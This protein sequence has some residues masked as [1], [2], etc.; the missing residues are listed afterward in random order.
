[1]RRTACGY[2]LPTRADL[3]V[4]FARN[5]ASLPQ[6]GVQALAIGQPENAPL[7]AATAANLD[8][9]ALKEDGLREAPLLTFARSR[10]LAAAVDL[11]F[12]GAANAPLPAIL[13]D[14]A[15]L[16]AVLP[17]AAR[18]AD[19]AQRYAAA[20]SHPAWLAGLADDEAFLDQ[21][22]AQVAAFAALPPG[23][24]GLAVAGGTVQALGLGDSLKSW[25]GNAAV[26]VR[27]AVS[28]L[29]S[30]A[31][32]A[33]VGTAKEGVREGFLTFPGLV[34]P[35]AS[36]LIGRFFGDVFTYMENRQ[37]ILDRVLADI[38]LA[39]QAKRPG[40]SEL[41][42]VAHSF[43]GIILYDI[44]TRFRPHLECDLYVTVGSQVAL[45]AEIG[46]LADKEPIAA[47]FAAG[48][49][50][51][52][53][54]PATVRRWLNVFDSTDFIGFG[55]RGVFAGARDYRFETDALP[56]VSHGAYFDTPRFFARLRERVRE[57]FANGTDTP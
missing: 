29:A 33:V 25:L 48:P 50:A 34:R 47:A 36:A 18:F 3:G 55:T 42:L 52:V 21:L 24:P 31:A 19:A 46:R 43:G 16:R 44:L 1:M 26:A 30:A 22:V 35:A 14:E 10:T 56:I 11:L 5:L 12:A 32:G 53:P 40:D 41:Y 8:A 45:F 20:N 39:V 57:A 54:R 23:T 7:F 15:G 28:N 2:S 17:E 4:T 38:D 13:F 49:K 37:L 27:D 51:V 9:E 6:S